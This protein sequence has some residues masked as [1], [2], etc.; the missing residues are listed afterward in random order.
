VDRLLELVPAEHGRFFEPFF[1][2]GALFWALQPSLATISDSNSDLMSCYATIRDRPGDVS[3]RLAE[4]PQDRDSYYRIRSSIPEDDVGRAARLVYLTTL[5]FN[6]I[7]RVNRRG[8]FNVPYGGRSYTRLR[9][10]SF[11]ERYADALRGAELATGDF[12]EMVE[13]ATPGDVVYLDPPYTVKHGSNGFIKYNERI[14]SWNDQKRLASVA[15]ELASRGCHVIV[16]NADHP[17]VRAL[18]DGFAAVVQTR[19]SAMAADIKHR[20]QIQE[21]V[22]TNVG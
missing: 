9:D 4:L 2:G 14:F 19:R 16:S 12:E 20:G 21:I 8:E 7:H 1:G 15:A 5:A 11:L 10:P 18:Y 3:A 22:F 13:A 17:S 6:G